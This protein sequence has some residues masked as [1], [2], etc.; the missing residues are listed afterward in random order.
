VIAGAQAIGLHQSFQEPALCNCEVTHFL[1]LLIAGQEAGISGLAD[2][3][4]EVRHRAPE[5]VA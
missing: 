1:A 4:G 5:S 2:E 3:S